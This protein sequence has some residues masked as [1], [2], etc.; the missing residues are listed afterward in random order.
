MK[1]PRLRNR[2][3]ARDLSC[4]SH[5]HHDRIQRRR[6]LSCSK[7]PINEGSNMI[8]GKLCGHCP[9]EVG[10]YTK[11]TFSSARQVALSFMSTTAVHIAG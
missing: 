2:C 10:K 1:I 11:I 9:L 4:V 3:V 7:K 5:P 8:S 6:Y